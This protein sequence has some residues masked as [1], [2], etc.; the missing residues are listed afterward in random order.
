MRKRVYSLLAALALLVTAAA[1]PMTAQAAGGL[2]LYTTYPGASVKAGDSRSISMYVANDTG[3]N[4][5]AD[6]TVTSMPEGWDGYFSGD[7][8]QISRVHVQN[9]EEAAVT[10]YLQIPEDAEAGTYGVQLQASSDTGL[11]DVLDLSLTI[12]EQEYGQGSLEAEYPEQEGASGTSFSFSATLINNGAADQSYSLSAQA[13]DGW[14]V[15]FSPSSE[16]TRVASME[17]EAGSSAGLTVSVTPPENVEA[18]EYTIP[19]SAASASDTLST[20]LKVTIT[21]TYELSLSTP[22]G[23]L[24]FDA[25][26]NKESDVTLS[27]TNNSNVD[28][29]NINLTSSAPSDWTVTFDT[30][31]ID[32]LEAGATQ[33]ITAHVTPGDSAMTGDY[34]TT[35]TASCS[36]VSDSAEFRVSVKT[37]TIW[38]IVAIL[39]ILGLIGGVG[40]VFRKYGRR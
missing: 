15:S 13:P 7:G 2:E 5:D 10:F 24:S 33:E 8:G 38:G 19:I 4:L 16:S 36:E 25:Q 26:A 3:A 1:A 29:Q 22:S 17:V 32:V 6:L 21:G 23:L 11:T 37:S 35:I 30:S 12:G 39:I 27:L 9:G 34:V 28:L 20:E 18:G 31:S 40:Y 14:Q